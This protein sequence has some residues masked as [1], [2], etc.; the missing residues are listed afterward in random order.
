MRYRNLC[1]QYKNLWMRWTYVRQTGDVPLFYTTAAAI[2]REAFLR[3]GRVRS[4]LRDAERRGHRV[5]PEARPARRPRAVIPTSRSSTS[6]GTRSTACCESTSCG[7]CRSTRLKLRHRG[8]LAQ[9]NTSVPSSYMASVPLVGRRR[10]APAARAR[11][12]APG[13]TAIGAARCGRHGAQLGFLTAIRAQRRLGVGRSRRSRPL[14]RAARRR[15][16]HR[17]RPRQLSV[18]TPLLTALKEIDRWVT[19]TTCSTGRRSS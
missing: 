2:R 11:A 17:R 16:R 4:G 10:P 9:N 7:R 13:M 1:S 5:R 3:V 8:D 14:A 12:S 19:S 18:R 6:S 15:R